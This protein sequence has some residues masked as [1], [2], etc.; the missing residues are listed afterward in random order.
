MT[1]DYYNWLKEQPER[2]KLEQT[3][4]KHREAFQQFNRDADNMMRKAF[5]FY[6]CS[7]KIEDSHNEW[8]VC[9]EGEDTSMEKIYGIHPE[10]IVDAQMEVAN[11]LK[12]LAF[13]KAE[14]AATINCSAGISKEAF[15]QAVEAI[16]TQ[17]EEL[18]TKF[19][20]L[21][22]KEESK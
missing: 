2:K 20:E 1:L 7:Q 9:S 22:P 11:M 19:E 18:K 15:D 14:A 21:N 8:Q 4:D 5:A 12:Q 13:Q 10:L 6:C 17:Y 3:R 16:G